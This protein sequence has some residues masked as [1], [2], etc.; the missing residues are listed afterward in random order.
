M[1]IGN[2]DDLDYAVR[3]LSGSRTNLKWSDAVFQDLDPG[4]DTSVYL[5]VGK[6]QG[7]GFVIIRNNSTTAT[8]QLTIDGGNIHNS[9][10]IVLNGQANAAETIRLDYFSNVDPGKNGFW[11]ASG[12]K[13]DG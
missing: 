1:S 4:G 10:D 9:A 5:P 2:P 13:F 3:T 7:K 12:P 11:V 8:E 6:T